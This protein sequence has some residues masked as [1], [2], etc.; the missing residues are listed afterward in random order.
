ML[1]PNPEIRGSG[2][3]RLREGRIGID[4]FPQDLMLQLEELNRDFTRAQRGS[5]I[6]GAPVT[7]RA[8]RADQRLDGWYVLVN[9]V[10]WNRNFHLRSA[11]LLAHLMEVIG[12][13]S[14]VATRKKKPGVDADGYVAKAIAWWL[15]LVWEGRAEER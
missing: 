6:G 9:S 10:Y 13:L 4:F 8:A 2:V 1:D 14:C 7:A 12:G 15:A 3:L 5:A 11:E